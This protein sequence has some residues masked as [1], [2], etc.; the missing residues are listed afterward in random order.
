[1]EFNSEIDIYLV[2]DEKQNEINIYLGRKIHYTVK[3]YQSGPYLRD[4]Y[5]IELYT[6]GSLTLYLND[7]PYEISEGDLYVIQSYTKARR[8]FNEDG[9]TTAY[10]GT[11]GLALHRYL[12]ALGF[13]QD[14]VI[15]PYKLAPMCIDSFK[16]S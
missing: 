8:L 3:K 6:S 15:F 1:M 4:F 10:I 9:T 14:T 16:I 5:D 7:V 13:S 11:K 12:K 2:G